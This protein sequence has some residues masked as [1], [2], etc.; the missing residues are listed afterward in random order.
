MKLGGAGLAALL[1]R[2]TWADAADI[3]SDHLPTRNAPAVPIILRSPQLELV[4]DRKDALPYQYRLRPSG[5]RMRGEDFGKS[6]R[7]VICDRKRWEFSALPIVAASVNATGNR[8][9]F[10]FRIPDET[11]PAVSFVL[12]YR[13]DG[14][15]VLI[16]LEDVH[17]SAGHELI[18]LELPCLVTVREEDGNAWLAHGDTGGSLVS[19]KEATPGQLASNRFWGNVSATL[20][21]VMLGTGR[22]LCVQEVTAF[23]DGTELE[24]VGANGHRRASIGTTQTHRVNGSLCYDMNT[25]TGTPFACGNR[26]TPNLPVEQKPSCR[27]DFI[28]APDG[29]VDWMT[30][31]KSIRDRMPGIPT[32]YYDNKLIYGIHCDEPH[33]EKPRATFAQCEELIRTISALTGNWPQ[34]VHLWGW[35]YRGKDTGYPAVAQVNKRLG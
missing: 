7:A 27:L 25:G 32:H 8:A 12:R 1:S 35:Q 5:M 24:V 26:Q 30:G 28:A 11:K 13:L 23:M 22:T 18:Q 16:T 29:G 3:A 21:V 10:R 19:L 14:S 17:E 34:V 6:I 33:F 2:S 20:P 9:D 4:L 15:T 31:A